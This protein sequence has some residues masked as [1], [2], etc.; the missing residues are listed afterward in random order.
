MHGAC[1]KR[2]RMVRESVA[3]LKL[4][5]L[6]YIYVCIYI[7][8]F[9]YDKKSVFLT[10]VFEDVVSRLCRST[11]D[12]FFVQVRRF[13]KEKLEASY[14]LDNSNLHKRVVSIDDSSHSRRSSAGAIPG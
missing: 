1:R 7:Y 14:P 8:L 9:T 6:L 2:M 11:D 10:S 12:N 3:F 5:S 13:F 4:S